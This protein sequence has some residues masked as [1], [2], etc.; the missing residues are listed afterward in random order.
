MKNRGYLS[1]S[2]PLGGNQ[3]N[4]GNHH[5]CV[6]KRIMQTCIVMIVQQLT[7]YTY[8]VRTYRTHD[9]DQ[10]QPGIIFRGQEKMH[11]KY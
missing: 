11:K 10:L 1:F 5:I 2:N 3:N 6:I 8:R 7:R 4:L 9:V